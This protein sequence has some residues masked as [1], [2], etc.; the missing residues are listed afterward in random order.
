MKK[1]FNVVKIILVSLAVA[2]GIA[3]LVLY[4]VDPELAKGIMD[5]VVDYLNRPLPIVGV[6]LAVLSA[7]AWK[8]F[9]STVF[10]KK[11][12]AEAKAQYEVQYNESKEKFYTALAIYGKE[13]DLISEAVLNACST[14]ANKKIKA[15][16]E[17]LSLS[18]KSQKEELEKKAHLVVETNVEALV[19]NQKQ[20][21]EEVVEKVRK[22]LLIYGEEGK[23]AAESISEATK[24]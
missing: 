18:L 16:G 20:I 13:I 9:S 1:F 7:L 14:S 19:L 10:G 21:A 23:K 24:I 15:L 12:L 8:I 17:E 5:T 3:Y 2:L 4:I 22:E 11:Y 6:S